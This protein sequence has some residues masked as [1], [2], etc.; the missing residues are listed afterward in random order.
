[1]YQFL[2]YAVLVGAVG[3]PL[4]SA[5]QAPNKSGSAADLER[6]TVPVAALPGNCH[7]RPIRGGMF[8]TNP[9]VVTEPNVLAFMHTLVFGMMPEDAAIGRARPGD[10]T[11]LMAARAADVEAGYAAA[12]E[13][14]GG[15]PEIGV[16]ALRMKNMPPPERLKAVDP[17]AA[18]IMKGSI[19]IFY[20]SDARA[21]APDGGCLDAVRRHIEAVDVR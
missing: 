12:Y 15:S 4:Q 11:N 16:Y 19:A 9:A 1:M 6:L 10:V 2:Y 13:E 5:G 3:A 20:W 17:P 21:D 14:Q 7:L 8:R 18:R